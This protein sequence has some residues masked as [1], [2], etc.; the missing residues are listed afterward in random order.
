MSKVKKEKIRL[1]SNKEGR[2]VNS[3]EKT[4]MF[5]SPKTKRSVGS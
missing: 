1:N 5:N 4:S 3:K 2:S